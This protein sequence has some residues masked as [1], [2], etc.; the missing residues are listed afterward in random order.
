MAARLK[1]LK[2]GVEVQNVDLGR[3]GK[4]TLMLG[5]GE[6]ADIRIDDRAVGREHAVFQVNG[7]VVAIQKKSKFG[8]MAINGAEINEGVVKPGDVISIA[9]YML[10]FEDG[11]P[12]V[13]AASAAP[14][15]SA[16]LP[17]SSADDP[18]DLASVPEGDTPGMAP[19]E[20]GG[21]E[22][23][24]GA[25][26]LENPEPLAISAPPEQPSMEAP[27]Q[28]SLA[29]ESPVEAGE[30]PSSDGF[31]P[32][33]GDRTAM[34]SVAKVINKLVFQPGA[35]NLEE[36]VITK[37]EIS[38]G[39][40]TT[41]DVIL[42]DKK[43]SRKHLVL[44]RVGMNFV[45][46]DLGSGNG[47]TVN[48]VRITEQELADGDVLKI[49][50]TDFVF[51]AVSQDYIQQEQNQEFIA[52]PPEEPEPDSDPNALAPI[53][54]G[55]GLP[56]EGGPAGND[57]HS[58][59]TGAVAGDIAGGAIP[60]LGAPGTSGKKQTPMGKAIAWFKAQPKP[61][62]IMIGIA[63]AII[64]FVIMSGDDE[65]AAKKKKPK[66]KPTP[67]VAVT[68]PDAMFNALP[69][70]KK[71]FVIN[72]YQISL[73]L[74][75]KG[76][77]EKAIYEITKVHTILS[78]GYKDSLEIARY[79]QKS[80]DIQ[81][82]ADEE[83][84]RKRKEEQNRKDLADLVA[85][86]EAAVN[87]GKDNEA[88]DLFAKILE[89]DP[90]NPTILRL[91]QQLEEKENQRKQ[92]E[93]EEKEKENKHKSLQA[94]VEEGR[95]LFSSGQYFTCIDKMG[96]AVL[97]L[98]TEPEMA[99][100]AKSLVAKS[101]KAIH[102]MTQPHLD[103]AKTAFD[104]GD[105]QTA[106]TEYYKALKVN[107][108]AY[109]AKEG[110]R[111]IRDIGH[112]RSKKIYVEGLIAESVSDYRS[113]KIKFKECLDSAVRED[114]YF[115]MCTRKYKRYDLLDRATAST[116]AA[117]PAS[118]PAPPKLPVAPVLPDAPTEP[119]PVSTGDNTSSASAGGAAAPPASGGG[120]STGTPQSSTSSAPAPV[121]APAPADKPPD[122]GVE[123]K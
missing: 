38:I 112:E 100:E 10:K 44:K 97:L 45:A 34:I 102:D 98:V 29:M 48:G 103:A 84:E 71:Q 36:L 106:R 61:R 33:A 14:A 74:Y 47:S 43:A 99:E 83:K 107:Y 120:T 7:N 89:H 78:G 72:N 65:D 37:S 62:Q 95:N 54:M 109:A 104:A 56:V 75:K 42:A 96:D 117:A 70:E 41:C 55:G 111:R 57:P 50:D 28:D 17:A 123:F 8:Q 67:T 15:A 16:P 18:P 51:K 86:A 85:A 24:N 101:K 122:G 49:G 40:G 73:D 88:K 5:R 121:P 11:T 94:V 19:L 58:A 59:S 3:F 68:G 87:A 76:E 79:A 20:A 23:E 6:N 66:P 12:A 108:Q 60:G 25:G 1:V 115:G 53:E 26:A 21:G 9:E 92:K 114:D 105:Y 116:G 30:A 52:P 31:S 91:R 77:Y 2:D 32:D 63:F 118:D 90:E 46:V 39:R 80:L 27:S 81:R 93:E 4:S 113:A 119:D 13:P 110:I 69:E 22:G 35:A 82:A 64:F